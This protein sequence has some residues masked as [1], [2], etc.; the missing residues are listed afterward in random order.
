MWRIGKPTLNYRTT[1]AASEEA[2]GE[3]QEGK[4]FNK[5]LSVCKKCK[6]T[7]ILQINNLETALCARS[8][9]SRC[10]SFRMNVFL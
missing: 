2:S 9:A 1:S 6:A 4:K 3:T 10:K 8:K 5:S 7:E